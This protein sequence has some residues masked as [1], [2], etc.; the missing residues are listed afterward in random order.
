MDVSLPTFADDMTLLSFSKAA[1]DRMLN[2]CHSYA[3]K[4]RYFY[5]ANKCAVMIFNKK[6]AQEDKT[7]KIGKEDVQLTNC[8]VHLG[9]QFDEDLSCH[10]QLH[11]SSVN[12]R[13][14]F[15]STVCN[16]L[17]AN[18]LNPMLIGTIYT[19]AIRPKALFGCEALKNC[20]S[21]DLQRLLRADR[22]CVKYSQRF[23]LSVNSNC[24]Y[25][26]LNVTP[27]N[28]EI[29]YRKLLM[30]GQLCRLPSDQ[31][32]KKVFVNRLIRFVNFDRQIRGFIPDIYRILQKYGLLDY[33]DCF[34]TT[35][36]FVSKPEWKR[37]LRKCINVS[38][39]V[40]TLHEQIHS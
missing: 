18:R 5:N 10:H 39:R 9:I 36:C 21:T 1:M 34:L 11:N 26:M 22:F 35:G 16:G 32:A 40:V 23:D 29:D 3:C 28:L 33:L 8:Q 15:I 30:L 31:F 12:L 6:G 27:I 37:V 38:W 7:F 13:G 14:T 20:S 25:I 24:A 17:M 19:S 2:I 4:W